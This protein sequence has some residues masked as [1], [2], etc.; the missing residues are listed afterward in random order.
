MQMEIAPSLRL[1]TALFLVHVLSMASV[2]L[3]SI[4]WFE[5]TFLILLILISFRFYQQ[6]LFYIRRIVKHEDNAWLLFDK[7]NACMHAGLTDRSYIT[8]WLTIL[9]FKIP[10]RK[11][12]IIVY[13]LK[14]STDPATLSKFKLLL[15]VQNPVFEN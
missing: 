3:L 6:R 13:L 1:I 2:M 4:G 5:K 7:D 12:K 9:V 11:N 8:E 15:K 10:Q 14:D